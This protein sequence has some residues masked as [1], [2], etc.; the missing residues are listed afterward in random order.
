MCTSIFG[1]KVLVSSDYRHTYLLAFA[2]PSV[3][4]GGKLT[5][6]AILRVLLTFLSIFH[7]TRKMPHGKRSHTQRFVRLVLTSKVVAAA[8]KVR[9]LTAATINVESMIV[10]LQ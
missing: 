1:S 10:A 8:N 4:L 6:N 3:T 5:K 7:S 2:L 9:S